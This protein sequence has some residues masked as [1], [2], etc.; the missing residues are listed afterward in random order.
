MSLSVENLDLFYGDAQALADV[1]LSVPDGGIVAVVG[2][3]GAGKSSLIRTIAGIERPRS[4]RIA[5]KDRDITGLPSHKVCNLGIAQVAEGRQIFGGLT[6]ME[7][8]EVGAYLPRGRA[9]KAAAIERVIAMFPRLEERHDQ[10]AGTLSGGEQQM[11]AIGRC[12]MSDP[13]LIMF[14]EPSLGLAPTLVHEVFETISALNEAGM[15]VILVEQNV[16]VSL[17]LA[18]HAY[19]LENARIVMDGPRRRPP[20]RRPRARGLSRALR[21]HRPSRRQAATYNYRGANH[22]LNSS[23]APA[24]RNGARCLKQHP[25]IKPRYQGRSPMT[26]QHPKFK[27]AAVQAAPEFLDL[28]GTVDKGIALIKSAAKNGA[29]L[30]AFPETWIPGYP[31]WIWLGSPAWGMQ[32][33]QCYHDNSLVVGSP[34]YQRIADAARDNDIVVVMGYS[35]KSGG[36]LYMGQ[37]II[38]ATGQ[39]VTNRRKLKPTHVER[40]VFGESDGSHIAVHDTEIGRLGALCCWEHLQPLTKY[41]MYAQHEQVHV[42][43]WPSFSLYLGMAYALGPQLN[44]AA[45]QMYAAEGQCFVLAATATTSPEMIEMLCDTPDKHEL[46]KAGGGFAMIFAPDGT[47]MAE[48]L[49]ED[50]EGLVYADI[51]LGM[52]SLAK[53]AADPVGHYSRPDVTRLLFNSTPRPPVQEFG[54]PLEVVDTSGEEPATNVED[55][56]STAS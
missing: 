44:M 9:G 24:P 18:N 47:P 34:E 25:A 11:L 6:V 35:E 20:S 26:T 14:D 37:A 52:I 43:S 21:W 15:T 10:L 4:G 27:A 23:H 29:K 53:S 50:Q 22:R 33:V 54:T 31:F 55:E 40:T 46:I 42:A 36:S 45:S 8:L 48:P 3:N 32:F 28:N 56:V 12:L 2:S 13:E 17:K 16:A 30:V 39:T 1:S 49:P 41:A 5:F 7:N 19:V 51:D 38:D